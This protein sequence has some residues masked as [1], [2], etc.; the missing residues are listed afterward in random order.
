MRNKDVGR[1]SRCFLSITAARCH[2]FGGRPGGENFIHF[3]EQK[4]PSMA[5]YA[6]IEV[7]AGLTVVT[8]PPGLTA[9]QQ[10]TR[11]AGVVVDP[12]PYETYEDA[13]DAL[14]ALSADEDDED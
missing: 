11:H 14:L 6:I 12:G 2:L 8:I 7:D 4:H 5:Y 10:A 9:E 13:Y 1:V 3:A